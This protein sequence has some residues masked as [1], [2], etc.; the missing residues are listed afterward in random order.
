MLPVS[1]D[2]N[3]KEVQKRL[4]QLAQEVMSEIT[5]LDSDHG[6]ELLGAFVSELFLAVAKQEQQDFRRQKQAEG[7]AAARARGVQFGRTPLPDNFS[8]C[9][10]A[11]QSGHMTQTQAAESC[12]ISRATFRREINRLKRDNSC[13]V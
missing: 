13:S 4:Q 12:G 11:W 3:D 6:K 7:I 9:Y 2:V 10:E 1:R 8:E 5:E